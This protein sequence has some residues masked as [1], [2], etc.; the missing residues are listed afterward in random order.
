MNGGSGPIEIL[1]RV[2]R[3]AFEK[4]EVEVAKKHCLCESF[5]PISKSVHLF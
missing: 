5:C 1:R 3:V 4:L 2:P